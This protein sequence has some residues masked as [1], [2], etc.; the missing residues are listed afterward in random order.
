[1]TNDLTF[2]IDKHGAITAVS[3]GPLEEKT[4]TGALLKTVHARCGATDHNFQS[5]FTPAEAAAELG[6]MIY[7]SKCGEVRPLKV[8]EEED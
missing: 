1:M 6:L 3:G 5:P 4:Y 2:D 8:E 7:C